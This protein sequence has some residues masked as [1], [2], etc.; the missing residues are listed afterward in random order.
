MSA[1]PEK[2][3]TIRP[4][5]AAAPPRGGWGSHAMAA[6]I[7]AL[8]AALLLA[9]IALVIAQGFVHEG[10]PSLYWFQ[11]VAGNPI[12]VGQMVN[13]MALASL[14]TLA[15]LALAV[16]LAVVRTRCKFLGAGLL[17][18]LLLVPLILPPFVGALSMKRLMAPY[19]AVN[20]LLAQAGLIDAS[21]GPPPDWF[22]T[23]F[24]GVIVLQTLHL[25]PI[26]YLNASAALANVDPAYVQA[27]RNLGASPLRAFFSVTLPLMR[28]G[29]FAGGTIVFIWSLT[30]IGTPLL[31]GFEEVIPVTVFKG[32]GVDDVSPRT[33]SLVF[34]MLAASVALYVLGKFVFGRGGAAEATKATIAGEVRRLG[35]AG[36]LGAWLL[37]GT[38]VGLALLPHAGVILTAISAHWVNTV[39]PSE[40]T[41]RHLQYVITRPDTYNSILNSLAY[42]GTSTAVD[43]VA[44]SIVAWLLVRGRIRGRTALDGLVMLPLAVPGL[45]LAAGYVA[46]TVK[47]STLYNL[48]INT[49]APFLLL[50]I[51]YAVRRLPFV[52][53]GVSAGLEQVPEALEEA[54]RNF[55]A[56]RIGAILRITLPLVV[57]NVIAAGALTFA[58]AMLE[59]SDSL[60]LAQSQPFY[61][62]TKEIY[63]QAASGNVD[64]ANIASALGVYGMVLLG[65]TFALAGALLGKKLGAI[66]RA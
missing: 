54:G 23:G 38:V 48:G 34:V 14:T 32:L 60:I 66:F 47:G 24:I 44:G 55:G 52:V 19:G 9:P 16:P 50:V 22:G 40:Y 37:F 59:V 6:L 53:R 43:L 42:A 4:L 2:V 33:F 63:K 39:L 57:A 30:D 46:M 31:L 1:P 20:L 10:H 17:S 21:A 5:L 45:I 49:K 58:F 64:A 3:Q 41:M 11:R 13:G 27:A 15:C 29:L 26:L 18:S 62:I 35:V 7:A 12:L 61:P 36:T 28:P 65:G 25:F 56:S 8:L 51:A